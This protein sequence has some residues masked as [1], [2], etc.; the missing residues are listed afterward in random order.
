MGIGQSQEQPP[1]HGPPVCVASPP[2]SATALL[3]KSEE[4][5]TAYASVPN[6]PLLPEEERPHN[7]EEET[8]PT[9]FTWNQGGHEVYI[10]GSFNK[11]K[12]KIPMRKSMGEFTIIK[13]LPPGVHQYK[14][15]VDGKWVHSPDQNIAADV[16]GNLNNCICVKRMPPELSKKSGPRSSY[17]QKPLQLEQ[18]VSEPPSLPPHL[19][20]ALLNTAFLDNED[21]LL[22]PLPHH[23]MLNHLYTLRRRDGELI[24]G[25]THRYKSKFVTAVLYKRD[26]IAEE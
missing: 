4:L 15:I 20:R 2:S 10:T 3:P 12:E 23:V 24:T 18:F 13:N 16:D 5:R 22:L 8:V 11:W 14:F 6:R 25:V 17:G 26:S 19:L 9:V 7:Y 1:E 21:P